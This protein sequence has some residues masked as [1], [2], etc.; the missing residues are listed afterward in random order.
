MPLIQK[1]LIANRGE[2]ALRIIR[3][4]KEM[5][6]QT[7]AVYSKADAESM[8]VKMADEAIC[9]GNGPSNE[10]YLKIANI[11]SAA[12]I[13][14][15]EA[16]HPGYG[17]L[18]EN[19]HFAEI[20]KSCNIKFIGP[21]PESIR[22]MGDKA[23]AKEMAKKLSVPVIPGS[24]GLVEDREEALKI[25][26]KLGYPVLIKATAGGGGKGM[27]IAHN[28]IS[29]AN[30]FLTART[31]AETSFNN[32]A[33]YLEKYLEQPRHIEVQILADTKGHVIHLG[34]RD[35]SIQRRHQKIIE[36]APSP[37][38]NDRLRTRMGRAAVK[39]AQAVKYVG[40]G[41]VEFLVD[42]H[43]NFYFLEMNTRIQVEHPITEE[44]TG[45]D[46]IKEQ[47][48][49]ASAK[50]LRI[51]QKDVKVNGAAIECRINAEDPEKGFMPS[52]GKV[53]K[54]HPAGGKGVRIDSHVYTGYTIPPFY[55]SMVAKVITHGEN[56]LD[57]I[58]KMIRALEEF[59]IEGIKTT[60]PLQL[61][62]LSDPVFQDGKTYS[63][64]Y[65]EQMLEGSKR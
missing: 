8:H 44:V 28:D 40:A 10:S 12:E 15:V 1:V 58:R 42:K 37:I 18:A 23:K 9:I 17:F 61:Q 5:G 41:T 6:I 22:Q 25:A 53:T 34:E 60:I 45:I 46:I 55:D 31:E 32:S 63:T 20:C 2:I 65:L 51:E 26:K 62:I 11:I 21:S 30:A 38:M 57:A 14:D 27:R 7:V 3:A 16:I 24:D 59:E 50:K 39:M 19:A 56:R 35:C 4:C 48:K 64:A 43:Q 52:A 49:I 13:G 36:E 33:V 29:L 54:Y 47:I